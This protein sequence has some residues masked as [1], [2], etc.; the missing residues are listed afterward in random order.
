M[1]TIRK[2]HFMIPSLASLPFFIFIHRIALTL[3]AAANLC[4]ITAALQLYHPSDYSNRNSVY[5]FED[6]PQLA[7]NILLFLASLY[8]FL[9]TTQW[10]QRV[11]GTAGLVL[12]GYNLALVGSQFKNMALNGGCNHGRIYNSPVSGTTTGT[13][14]PLQNMTPLKRRCEI[15]MVVGIIGV[16]WSVLLAA[17]LVMTNLQRKR[18]LDQK[19]QTHQSAYRE[20]L[21]NQQQS[22]SVVHLYQPDLSINRAG[23]TRGDG[24]SLRCSSSLELEPLPAYEQRPTGPQAQIIDMGSMVMVSIGPSARP[25]STSIAAQ[26]PLPEM[27][28][29]PPP[30]Y[31][32]T[33]Y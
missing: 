11:R 23:A 1:P 24:S 22:S 7:A 18:E 25:N 32:A 4:A 14:S 8:S 2:M 26:R 10:S 29:S 16:L 31:Q 9:G 3:L 17:E 12:I 13:T 21:R 5:N 33:H 20:H 15:Q 27:I 6:A 30:S 28:Q 19:I